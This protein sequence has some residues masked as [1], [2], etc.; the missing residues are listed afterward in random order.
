MGDYTA[1][2]ASIKLNPTGM[3]IVSEYL[4]SRNQ[5]WNTLT[6]E[7]PDL[8]FPRLPRCERIGFGGSESFTHSRTYNKYDY[9]NTLKEGVWNFK[10]SFKNY[11][12]EIETFRREILPIIAEKVLVFRVL[13]PR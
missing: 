6:T 13:G 1:L 4:G 3:R 9:H 10:C 5:G 8:K 2:I 12:D 7:Y 11:D